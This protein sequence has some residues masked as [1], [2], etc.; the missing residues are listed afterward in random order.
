MMRI[1]RGFLAG[2]FA[3]SL[4]LFVLFHLYQQQNVDATP[5]EITCGEETLS[6]SVSDEESALLSGVTAYDEKDGD[7]TSSLVVVSKSRF[8]GDGTREVELA[9]FD[10]AGNVA[11]ATRT[12]AYTDYTP[13]RFGL[14]GPLRFNASDYT[15]TV[16]NLITATDGLDG[17]ITS[18]IKYSVGDSSFSYGVACD[19]DI[20]FQVTT[21][22]GS[23][24]QLILK[25]AIL[26]EEEYEKPYPELSEYL[27]Y[28]KVGTE[29]DLESYPVG[30]YAYGNHYL[31]SSYDEDE[32]YV[33]ITEDYYVRENVTCSGTVDYSTPGTYVV[34]YTLHAREIA[35]GDEAEQGSVRLYVVVEE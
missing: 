28:T 31:F 9:A 32:D 5:P 34:T 19:A 7:V 10:A 16:S 21:S 23:S 3:V 20:A 17:T 6:V 26:S 1:L 12:I 15:V 11:T 33:G 8:A 25:A 22:A 30:T 13:P 35:D 29:L 18:L 14:T 24:A 2:L 27:V 4:A